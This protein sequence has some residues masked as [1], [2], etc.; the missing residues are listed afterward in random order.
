MK[1]QEDAAG[2]IKGL[3]ASTWENLYF[4]RGLKG[5]GAVVDKGPATIEGV[6]CERVDFVHGPDL[7]FERYFD[8]DTGRLVFTMRGQETIREAG[9][10]RVDG[11]RFPKTIVSVTKTA[12]GKDMVSTVTF[13]SIVLNEPA[14]SEMFAV[15]NIAPA[16]AGPAAARPPVK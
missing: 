13:E 6:V 11:I 4:F 2:D 15:P 7:V 12:S 10:I 14:G 1:S 9:E 3:R 8:R 16:K 5:D